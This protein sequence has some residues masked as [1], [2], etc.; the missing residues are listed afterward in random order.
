MLCIAL[1][2]GTVDDFYKSAGF[3]KVVASNQMMLE[4]ADAGAA[5]DENL[6]Q[7][8]AAMLICS[9]TGL[10]LKKPLPVCFWSRVEKAVV[11]CTVLKVKQSVYLDPNN[12]AV[13]MSYLLL[14]FTEVHQPRLSEI[15]E[16]YTVDEAAVLKV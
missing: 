7:G 5:L 13:Q 1:Q 6:T 11:C 12:P 2:S 10:Q 4:L 3:I 8:S 16:A 9:D 15:L 14:F